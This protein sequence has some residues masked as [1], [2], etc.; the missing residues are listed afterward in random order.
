[1]CNVLRLRLRS[2]GNPC[3]RLPRCDGRLRLLP[4]RVALPLSYVI[5]VQ[6]SSLLEDDL[7]QGYLPSQTPGRWVTAEVRPPPSCA[8]Q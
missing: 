5:N 3:A 4:T 6:S 8:A 7:Y 2:D 1:M